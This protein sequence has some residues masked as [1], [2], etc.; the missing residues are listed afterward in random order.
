[1]FRQDL[2]VLSND[3]V[4]FFWAVELN[5]AVFD[6]DLSR[7][8]WKADTSSFSLRDKWTGLELECSFD[9]CYTVYCYP[10]YTVNQTEKGLKKTLQGTCVLFGRKE[11]WT[12]S[13]GP[14]VADMTMRIR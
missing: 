3:T 14:V 9:G 8:P 7:A 12:P 13:N 1:M 10:V 11:N 5:L 2:E 4:S 6:E